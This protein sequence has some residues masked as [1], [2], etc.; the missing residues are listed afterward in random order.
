MEKEAKKMH[1]WKFESM[2]FQKQSR[3]SQE[4]QIDY[5]M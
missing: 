3:Q 1:F 2:Q 4:K 5:E